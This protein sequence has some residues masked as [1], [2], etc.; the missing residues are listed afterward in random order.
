MSRSRLPSA[1]RS[2][3]R[4]HQARQRIATNRQRG[5]ESKEADSTI[6]ISSVPAAMVRSRT[7]KVAETASSNAP[8]VSDPRTSE[9]TKRDENRAPV[10]DGPIGSF[11]V[12]S[13]HTKEPPITT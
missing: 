12:L 5:A 3:R 11:G 9:E 6:L 2:L 10:P 4:D 8:R 1:H 13:R 7:A